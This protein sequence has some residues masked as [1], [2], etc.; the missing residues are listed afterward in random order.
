M[1]AM[2]VTVL[3]AESTGKTELIQQLQRVNTT[4]DHR[5]MTCIPEPLRLFCEREK[6]VPNRFEQGTLLRAHAQ[7]ILAAA[8]EPT[9]VLIV[10]DCAPITTALYSQ[11]YYQDANL[12]ETATQFHHE[13]VGMT[14]YLPPEFGWHA[15]PNPIMRDSE[16]AQQAFDSLLAQWMT[17]EAIEPIV[18]LTG[19][20]A[21][22]ADLANTAMM[23]LNARGPNLQ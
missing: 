13:Y 12:M 4:M 6:R 15:D 22:R 14:L 1:A 3:G 19:S 10:C 9:A 2:I 5:A 7:Q 18:R 16:Q 11:L 23:S 17:R 21:Q 20:T 8:A